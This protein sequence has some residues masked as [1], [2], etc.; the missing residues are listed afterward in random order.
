[1]IIRTTSL[2][3]LAWQSGCA[4]QPEVVTKGPVP[5]MPEAEATTQYTDTFNR[6]INENNDFL[7]SDQQFILAMSKQPAPG[8]IEEAT[9]ALGLVRYVLHLKT[10]DTSVGSEQLID[11]E[12]AGTSN[13]SL[14]ALSLEREF[15]FAAAIRGNPLL[16]DLQFYKLTLRAVKATS[17]S[18]SFTAEVND[19]VSKGLNA[20]RQ[21]Q[22]QE[23]PEIKRDH[24]PIDLRI[25]DHI[26]LEAQTLA[27]NRRFDEAIQKAKQIG[28]DSPLYQNA[29]IKIVEFSDLAVQELRQKAALA[30]QNSIPVSD[31]KTKAAYLAS[32][33]E[34]LQKALQEYPAAPSEQLMTV[35]EN[36]TVISR[37]LEKL[38]SEE[39]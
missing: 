25:G 17:N 15:Q 9:L 11:P 6:L 16:K 14:E 21:Q 20:W 4:H 13:T 30:F 32:A 28:S 7:E 18:G 29:T 22:D 12:T 10:M 1:M 39:H 36:L 31:P 27:D 34:H 38:D 19:A 5:A 35:K 24:D 33:K 37:D 2:I 8:S 3:W 26:L 23:L